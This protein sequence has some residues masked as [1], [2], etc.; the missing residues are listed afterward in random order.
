MKFRARTAIGID[1]SSHSAGLVVLRQEKDGI[2]L[3]RAARRPIKGGLEE[4]PRAL[5]RIAKELRRVSKVKGIP[6]TG[7]LYSPRDLM[8]IVEIPPTITGHKG[9]YIQKEIRHYVTLAGVNVV[10]DYRDLHSTT[11]NERMLVVAGDSE[12][13]TETVNSYQQAGLDIDVVEPQLLAYVRAL[14]QQR[15]AGRFGCNVLLALVREGKLFLVVMRERNIDFVRTKA[16]AD[17]PDDPDAVLKQLQAEI[18]IIMQ[19]YALEVADSTGHWEVNI[20]ADDESTLLPESTQASL[21]DTLGEIPLEILTSENI[22]TALSIEIPSGIPSD[23]ISAVAIGHAM[24]VLCPE[25]VLPKINCLPPLIKEIKEIKRSML[26]T[27]IL[28]AMILLIMGLVTLVLIQR[29]DRMN[30]RIASQKP[31]SAMGQVADQHGAL[32]AEIEQVERI[33]KRLKEI[34]SS[35]ENV[36]W[37]RVLTDIKEGIPED[38][39]IARFNAKS[40]FS[41]HIDGVA[42]HSNGITRFLSRLNK[43]EYLDA[44]DLVKTDYKKS[45]QTGHH[46][47]EIRCQLATS[48]G[49]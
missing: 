12:S 4:N 20:V 19:Y 38:V 49:T 11:E 46:V 18:K 32:N 29:G 30:A 13:I 39:S 47:Y 43:S 7:S 3:L 6:A 27:A 22:G 45:G 42:L 41:V 24:R 48:I 15:I 21:A 44:V 5:K 1:I 31:A 40:D 33:P 16:L 17:D 8:Q 10:S 26:L 25:I 9:Q 34:L 14:Y 23:Q 28:A 35:Q 2:R 37:A 36:N